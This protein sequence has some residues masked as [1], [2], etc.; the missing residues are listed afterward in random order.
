MEE[1]TFHSLQVTS[2]MAHYIMGVWL[3]REIGHIRYDASLWD[4]LFPR[5][6]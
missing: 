6:C 4:P 3:V 1:S 2:E 5:I